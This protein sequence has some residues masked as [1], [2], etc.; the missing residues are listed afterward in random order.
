MFDRVKAAGDVQISKISLITKKGEVD[1]MLVF[2]EANIYEDIHSPAL[3][4]V[5]TITD[6]Q[7]LLQK[8]PITGNEVIKLEYQTP[9]FDNTNRISQDFVI[10]K[11]ADKSIGATDHHLV[12]NL[13]CVTPEAAV[14]MGMKI[15]KKFEGT[16]DTV[17]RKIL[18][19]YFRT[20]KQMTYDIPGNSISFVSP[21]WSP[22]KVISYYATQSTKTTTQAPNYMFFETNK[23][24]KFSSLETLYEKAPVCTYRHDNNPLKK[25][26]IRDIQSEYEQCLEVYF[27]DQYNEKDR[28]DAGIH[29]TTAYIHDV[30]SKSLKSVR[31]G[32]TE[33][34]AKTQHL[35]KYPMIPNETAKHRIV[36][37]KQSYTKGH[38]NFNIDNSGYVRNMRTPLLYDLELLKLDITVYGRTDLEVG[39]IVEFQMN[40]WN[41]KTNTDKSAPQEDKYYNGKYI[42]TAMHHRLNQ[43]QHQIVMQIA[44]NASEAPL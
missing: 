6:T 40:T 4:A 8:L 29:H 44:K 39:D 16:A 26:G 38:N 32:Y 24:Y 34:F 1:L 30:T 2:L 7:G 12:Y 14:D 41:E 23:Q 10:T 37:H 33:S 17:I 20:D 3:S 43:H 28:I 13:Y 42:I 15:S 21:F 22:F 31:F 27:G 18:R 35:G 11:I 5:I 36:T 9:G 19:E 25:D